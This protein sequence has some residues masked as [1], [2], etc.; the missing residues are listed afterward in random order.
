MYL[1]LCLCMVKHLCTYLH[2]FTS[3]SFHQP[4]PV[5]ESVLPIADNEEDEIR[6]IAEMQKRDSLIRGLGI[7]E[8]LQ[9]LLSN[10]SL[11]TYNASQLPVCQTITVN[12]Q[13]VHMYIR[14]Y[15]CNRIRISSNCVELI[16]GKGHLSTLGASRDAVFLVL[17]SAKRFDPG[18]LL[19]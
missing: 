8:M 19:Q 7:P 17:L 1:H 18:G 9:Y 11:S 15:V 12:Y 6:R 3:H 13:Y 4:L 10:E 14:T 16:F 5:N 2:T